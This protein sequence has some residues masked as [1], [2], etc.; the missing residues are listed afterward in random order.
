M[1]DEKTV[2]EILGELYPEQ[3]QQKREW[4]ALELKE[5]LKIKLSERM[6]DPREDQFWNEME[7]EMRRALHLDPLTDEEA[8]REYD[9]APEVP[10][11][12]EQIAEFARIAGPDCTGFAY[13]PEMRTY[14]AIL[15]DRDTPKIDIRAASLADAKRIAA[16]QRLPVDSWAPSP[17]PSEAAASLSHAGTLDPASIA[18]RQA[19]HADRTL[20]ALERIDRRLSDPAPILI[21]KRS[22]RRLSGAIGWQVLL[23]LIVYTVLMIVLGVVLGAVGA[24]LTGAAFGAI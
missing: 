19:D 7:P 12:E 14:T 16:E 3:A 23:A 20:A 11:S 17:T 8:A 6:T 1:A 2:R 10:L 18:A 13:T 24:A 4:L 5:H 22:V 15:R 21:D 9:E